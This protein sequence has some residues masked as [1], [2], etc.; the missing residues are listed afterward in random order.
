MAVMFKEIESGQYWNLFVNGLKTP[1][2]FKVF[3]T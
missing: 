1:K 2:H 3:K